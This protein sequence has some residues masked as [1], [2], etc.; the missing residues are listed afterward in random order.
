MTGPAQSG[1]NPP[2]RFELLQAPGCWLLVVIG[3]LLISLVYLPSLNTPFDFIDDGNLVYPAP[4]M[5]F[6]QRLLLVWQKI[7]ANYRDLGPFRPT[8]WLHWEAAAEL[9]NA[10]PF[11]WRMA[12]LVWCG[13]SSAMFLWLMCELRMHPLAGLLA[14]SAAMWNPFRNEIWLSLTLGEGVAMP[15]A[16]L[17]MI[18]A[19][20]AGRSGSPGLWDLVGAGS[21][22]VA[23]GCKNTF[24][25]VIPAQVY[26][27]VAANDSNWRQAW[28]EH[29]KRACLLALTL[30]LPLAHF[31]WFKL[32]WQPGQ[33]QPDFP[34]VGQALRMV[35]GLKGAISLD[36]LG[37]GMVLTIIALALSSRSNS[38]QSTPY[39][40]TSD[41]ES[42]PWSRHR[43]ALTA[44]ALL[45]A[46]GIGVYL[47]INAVS[48]RYTIPAVWG[49]DI[50]LAVLLSRLFAS[51][52]SVWKR[53][54][55]IALICGLITVAVAIVG[56]QLKFAARARLLWQ[57]LTWVEQQAPQDACI[58]WVGR[59]HVGAA[60]SQST[61]RDDPIQKLGVEE[62]IH[63][64]W[65]LAERGRRD[66]P[67]NIMDDGG[68]PAGRR[69]LVD[70]ACS[71]NLVITAK[72]EIP[73]PLSELGTAWRMQHFHEPYWWGQRGFDC[74]V[75]T[76]TPMAGGVAQ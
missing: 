48:G 27:R 45:L 47:P 19:I 73:R 60:P 76:L 51:P 36:F 20:R 4:A 30:V 42:L 70:V 31:T 56:K 46:A 62:G 72:A 64:A 25:A 41:P 35:S 22:I 2:S 61:H 67:F 7:A 71:P 13:L 57:A 26:L 49:L 54:A 59:P 37:A 58:A 63:F 44:A 43:L 55:L 65:H 3:A 28:R 53:V 8:L 14:V 50:G 32:N 24:M 34:A 16:L 12:R 29:G 66:L 39:S 18:C 33:Y 17:S 21:I 23:L 74:F 75:W 38:R 9:F 40:G 10:N 5:P 15:Y 6:G 1:L 52:Q 69:E 68:R 11:P